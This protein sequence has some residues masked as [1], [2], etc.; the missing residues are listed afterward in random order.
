MANGLI[1]VELEALAKAAMRIALAME[2]ANEYEQA[3]QCLAQRE[4]SISNPEH[5]R[6]AP[7]LS[8]C[9][10]KQGHNARR[11]NYIHQDKDGRTWP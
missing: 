10:L 5:A 7:P 8:R 6:G 11:G 4:W 1:V 2:S 3:P 9:L